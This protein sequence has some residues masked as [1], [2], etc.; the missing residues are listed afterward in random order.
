MFRNLVFPWPGCS[1]FSSPNENTLQH[2]ISTV[3]RY[4]H[5]MGVQESLCKEVME[6]LLS[7][8]ATRFLL[9]QC[10]VPLQHDVLRII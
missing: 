10:I 3:G 1:N 9:P 8:H 2:N 5:I 7:C 6:E 4:D